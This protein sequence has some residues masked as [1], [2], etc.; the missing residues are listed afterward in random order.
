[1]WAREDLKGNLSANAREARYFL[2]QKS[3]PSSALLITGHTLDDQAETFLMRL[4]RGSGVDGLSSMAERSYLSF[5]GDD[6]MIFRPLLKFERQTLRDVLNFHEVK[7]LEDPTNSD[8][9]FE[10][11]RVRKLLTS[12]AELG[13]DKT[14]ISKTASLMQSAKTALNHFAVDCYEKFGSCMYGDIIF[15]FEEFSNLPLD[16]KRRLLAAAQQWVSSQKYR[17]RLSQIDALLDSINEK[18]AFSGS[19]TICYFHDKSIKIT[20]ELNSCVNEVEAANGLIFDNR[21]ELST[22]ANCTEFT[23]KCLGENGF[24]FLDANVRK[25]IPYKT[26]IALPALFKDSALIDFPFLDPQSKFSFNFCKQPFDQFLL[27]H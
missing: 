19:G 5:G 12:F 4:R 17:P 23:V 6:I 24:K 7:W 13:L 26:I 18:T 1:M 20:R 14:K 15:D 21:W 27:D 8:D 25:E 2:M 11:V 3:L 16:I 22:S 10:R 9:S